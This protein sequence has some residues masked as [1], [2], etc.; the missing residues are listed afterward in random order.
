[1][2][3][4]TTAADTTIDTA[5][6]AGADTTTTE[7]APASATTTEATST[8]TS[9]TAANT[10][11]TDST[12]QD[13]NDAD[14]AERD[15]QGR[16]KPKIQKRI[17]ELTH[18]RRAAERER[19]Y[20]RSQ[21]ERQATAAPAPQAHEFA[22]DEEYDAAVRRHEIKQATRE[23]IAETAKA[24]AD[25]FDQDA[26]HALDQTY[27]QRVQ[28]AIAKMPDFVQALTNAKVDIPDSMT[29]ALKESEFG[30]EIAYHYATHPDEAARLAGM[31]TRQLDREIGRMEATFATKAA[32]ASAAV[33][34][35]AARTTK[36]PAPAGVGETS[37]T[38][39]PNTN[40]DKMSQEEF[41]VWARAN[42]SKYI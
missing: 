25:R 22:T 9:T 42:G 10:D 34:A 17:D 20:W 26:Q 30:P 33:A 31:S 32:P 1:M 5:Q 27:G 11:G 12:Q 41:E 36:A 39:P 16:F 37:G 38:A 15:E 7:A 2:Q 8:D 24:T 3:T 29:P 21:A 40:P 6:T 18:A 13:Q 28:A 14:P 35:P 19:D 23:E 4:E